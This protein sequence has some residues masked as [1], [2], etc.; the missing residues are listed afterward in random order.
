MSQPSPTDQGPHRIE[1]LAIL[2]LN[3]PVTVEDVKQAYLD[4]VKVAHP[5]HGGDAQQFIRLHE[6]FQQATE[7]AQFKAGRMQWLSRWV[8]Q[9]ADQQN[10]VE[11]IEELGG[12]VEIESVGW[13]TQS[14]GPDFATVLDRIVVLQLAGPTIDNRVLHDFAT[15]RRALSGVR[16]LELTDTKVTS[17]GLSALH[18]CQ[19]LRYLDLSGTRVRAQA[20]RAL[21]EKLPS[22]ETLVLDNTGIGWWSKL[23]FRWFRPGLI[24]T[25]SRDTSAPA[26]L[27]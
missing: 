15:Q 18:D 5:D 7:Y 1:C 11:E 14:I 9:Y 16:R 6:A 24:F 23:R 12:S 21:L 19:S 26:G 20:V 8:E 10:V 22:L 27:V 4:K 2:G 13:L 3:P 25:A 17:T